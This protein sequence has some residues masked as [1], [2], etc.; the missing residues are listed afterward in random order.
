M[1]KLYFPLR[2]RSDND[3]T[4]LEDTRALY[5]FQS[6]QL[7]TNPIHLL[8]LDQSFLH[9][10]SKIGLVQGHLGVVAEMAAAHL[11]HL[12]S[13]TV[14]VGMERWLS[15][16]PMSTEEEE[17]YSQNENGPVWVSFKQNN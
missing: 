2:L 16:K 14:S 10:H 6:H 5:E 11:S 3:E 15:W 13:N 7:P 8:P 9:P 17:E 4:F 1:K 12:W